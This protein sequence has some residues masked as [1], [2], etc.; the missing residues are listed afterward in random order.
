MRQ[1]ELESLCAYILRFYV[2]EGRKIITKSP[3][4]VQLIGYYLNTLCYI[5]F[6][7]PQK[8]HTM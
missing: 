5:L 6:L 4:G 3:N 2:R 8:K 1:N 7:I